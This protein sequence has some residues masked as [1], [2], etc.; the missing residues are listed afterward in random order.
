MNNALVSNWNKVVAP[1][2]IVFHLG[3]FCFGDRKT[4]KSFCSKLNGTKYL[5]QGNHDRENEIYYEGFESV[6][7]IAQVAI[8]DNELED[9]S[10]LILCHY[11]L[12]TWPGQWNGAVHCFGHSHTSPYSQNQADYD[13][14]QHR[15]LPSYDVGVDNNNFTPISYDELKTIF[16]KQLLYGHH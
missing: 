11:C 1:N 2:D 3:D 12:T 14:I 4:W 13:Y 8:Y 9:Y 7:D 6:C 15:A 16:T 10:T 5:I